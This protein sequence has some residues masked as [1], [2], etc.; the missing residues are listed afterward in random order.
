MYS[1]I[2]NHKIT[3]FVGLFEYVCACAL[4]QNRSNKIYLFSFVENIKNRSPQSQ[5]SCNWLR[6]PSVIS[7][8]VNLVICLLHTWSNE[9]QFWITNLFTFISVRFPA[10]RASLGSNS[11]F[12]RVGIF[13]YRIAITW[14]TKKNNLWNTNFIYYKF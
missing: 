6:M 12:G 5:Q 10:P 7:K 2:I 14:K 8:N 13:G 4:S 9:P 11:W 1:I 3:E